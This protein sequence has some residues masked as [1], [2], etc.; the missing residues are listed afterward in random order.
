MASEDNVLLA[1]E[2]QRIIRSILDREGVVRNAEL[3]ELLN[4]SLVTI[5][6]DL[7]ELEAAGECEIIWG[8]AVSRRPSPEHEMLLDERSKLNP[9]AK[10]RIG[11]YAASLIE[12]GQ[13]VILDAGTTTVE[14]IHHLSH[15]I[16]YLRIV[17][18]ALNVAAAAGYFPNIELVMTGGV[19]RNLTRSLIGP[20]VIR[21]LEMFNADLVFLATGG[22]SLREGVTTSNILEVE[23]KRTM[24]Q[25]GKRVILLA[26]SSK[27]GNVLSLT[28][29]PLENIHLL[30]TDSGLAE[31]E[32]QAI[33]ACGVEVVRT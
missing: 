19:L 12:V 2:R 28:V 22:F 20:Q 25:R 5:R 33:T 17:T 21:T 8:G 10:R 3:R 6:S 30:V 29:T 27:Y 1:V 26:D 14:V 7:R 18:P 15:E 23:V 4:V 24:V 13:T 16:D 11:E 32:V 31:S 9:E